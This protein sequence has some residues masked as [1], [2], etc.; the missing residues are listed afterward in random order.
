M[1][2]FIY[3]YRNRSKSVRALKQKLG[4]KSIKLEGSRY[5]HRPGHLVINWGNGSC[6]YP[7][8]NVPNAVIQGSNKVR[9][10][11]ILNGVEGVQIV[12][13]TTSKD[14]AKKWKLV[15]VRHLTRASGGKGIQLVNPKEE[16]IP[17]APL[18]QKYVKK[19]SEFRIHVF[20]GRVIH[21]QQKRRRND[22]ENPN[23]K[24]RNHENGFVFSIYDVDPVP[25]SVHDM[26]VKAAQQLGL[27]FGA[28]DVLWNA[29]E[30]KY[31]LLEVN[32]APGLEGTTL[33][34]YSDA[35]K[36]VINHA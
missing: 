18:Y 16:E 2:T 27:D 30:N 28:F 21:I 13:F 22:I 36:G 15:V 9:F 33:D 34:R 11:Q 8:L 4:A 32:T 3:P 24:V 7:C 17:N 23:W 10:S 12:P 31:Y 1:K 29:H 6:P 35:I 26:C 19:K 25:Q 20:Q 5:Q 14:E